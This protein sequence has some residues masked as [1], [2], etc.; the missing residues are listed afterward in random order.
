MPGY[1]LYALK[2]GGH[3]EQPPD[4]VTLE[5]DQEA[6]AHVS[7]LIDC[8]DVDGCDGPRFVTRIS[9]TVGL[10]LRKS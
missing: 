7:R 4:I 8:H 10:R 5:N 3:I 1:R 6:I 2:D 9:A